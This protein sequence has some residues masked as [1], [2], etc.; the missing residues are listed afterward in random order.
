MHLWDNFNTAYAV[1]V[2]ETPTYSIASHH[3]SLA[4]IIDPSPYN[5]PSS[6]NQAFLARMQGMNF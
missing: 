2:L 3:G 1:A 6:F 5:V 4:H